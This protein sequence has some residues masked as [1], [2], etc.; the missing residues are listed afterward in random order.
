MQLLDGFHQPSGQRVTW[1][2]ISWELWSGT[3]LSAVTSLLN[4]F[5]YSAG[6]PLFTKIKYLNVSAFPVRNK[7]DDPN[8]LNMKEFQQSNYYLSA[9]ALAVNEG[10][11]IYLRELSAFLAH[12]GESFAH[13]S[14]R[15]HFWRQMSLPGFPF[16]S[17]ATLHPCYSIHLF[18]LFSARLIHSVLTRRLMGNW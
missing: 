15:S 14:Q 10:R 1:Y 7:N 13:L 12:K 11:L 4:R 8:Y 17:L 16:D 18:V 9:N 6:N 3:K 5:I 2:H